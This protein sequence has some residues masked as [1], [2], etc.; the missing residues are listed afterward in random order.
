ML[1]QLYIFSLVLSAILLV[2]SLLVGDNSPDGAGDQEAGLDQSDPSEIGQ[3]DGVQPSPK[4]FLLAS[5]K[6]IRFW[7]FFA[8]FFGMTGLVLDGLDV[9]IPTVALLVA[10]GTGIIVGAG[11]NAAVRI[12]SA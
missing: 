4:Q 2:A 5:F 12:L 6:S 7:T 9:M 8:A 10:I 11:A 3:L 1:I